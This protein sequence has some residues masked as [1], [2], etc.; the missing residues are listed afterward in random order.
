M[1]SSQKK[2]RQTDKG[3]KSYFKS[4]WKSR[5]VKGD[6]DKLYDYVNS[7]E[8]CEKCSKV[9]TDTYDRILDHNHETGEFRFVLCRDCNFHFE[10][11]YSRGI[12]YC[13][14]RSGKSLNKRWRYT[15]TTNGKKHTKHHMTKIDALCYKF[16]YILKVKCRVININGLVSDK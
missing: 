9:F 8:K 14:P 2:Y 15:K 6:L 10:K 16:I 1:Y 11:G 7:C 13:K 5:G 3:R 4:R 12:T